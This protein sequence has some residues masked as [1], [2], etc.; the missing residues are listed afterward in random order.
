MKI[1]NRRNLII[2][3]I[4]LI[5]ASVTLSQHLGKKN[6][7]ALQQ[8]EGLPAARE[9]LPALG[10]ALP[11]ESGPK[12][13]LLAP[14]FTIQGEDGTA[15]AVGGARNKAVLLNFWASWCD[16]C[17]KEAPELNKI[18]EKYKGTLD[19][20]GINVTSYDYKANAQRFVKKYNLAFPVMFD[21]KG[22]AYAKYNGTVFPTNVLIDR[23]GVVA[24]IILGG[25]TAEQM[26]EKL[27]K[28]VQ[29]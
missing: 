29:Q 27:K 5:A 11:T 18:A 15:Y 1:A 6:E 4:A 23:N 28:L 7:T 13:G 12:V 2:A 10:M 16:P 17:Q 3:V 24:E 22:E 8:N 9:T 25:L 20:Y 26:D 21:L 19:I 14:S